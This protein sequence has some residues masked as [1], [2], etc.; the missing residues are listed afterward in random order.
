MKLKTKLLRFMINHNGISIMVRS[1]KNN[2]LFS[3]SI[4][5]RLGTW[6]YMDIFNKTIFAKQF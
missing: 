1:F 5:T 3:L 2:R 4:D 6:I